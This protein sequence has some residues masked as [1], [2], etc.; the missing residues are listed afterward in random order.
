MLSI[1]KETIIK[2]V[3]TQPIVSINSILI[4]HLVSI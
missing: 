2:K 4:I 3:A 1:K